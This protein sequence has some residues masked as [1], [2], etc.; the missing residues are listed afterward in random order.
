MS[1]PEN[2]EFSE[3][4]PAHFWRTEIPNCIDD[5]GLDPSEYRLYCHIKRIAGDRGACFKSINSLAEHCKIGKTKLKEC[6][7]SLCETNEFLGVPLLKKQ[8]RTTKLG[9]KDT[10]LYIVKDIWHLNSKFYNKKQN[11]GGSPNDPGV[12]RQATEGRLPGDHKEEPIKKEPL[13]ENLPPSQAKPTHIL[14]PNE[15]GEALALALA[16][17]GEKIQE[18]SSHA[19]KGQSET[20][21]YAGPGFIAKSITRSDIY[22]YMMKWGYDEEIIQE[23]IEKFMDFKK[24]INNPY[25][26]LESKCKFAYEDR[27]KIKEGTDIIEK[28]KTKEEEYQRKLEE[29]KKQPKPD[30]SKYF[31]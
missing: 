12:G 13:E 19:K 14:T 17:E 11:R 31:K 6:L 24:P 10:N 22:R 27:K 26:L 4:T 9:D 5:C 7:A 16:Q 20:I 2:F 8:N 30:M 25:K 28:Q 3:E 18:I 29:R 15:G 1:D 21:H 23:G